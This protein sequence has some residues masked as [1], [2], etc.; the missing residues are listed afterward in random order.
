MNARRSTAIALVVQ[1]VMAS[2]CVVDALVTDSWAWF[3]W[4]C[5]AICAGFG[6][7]TLRQ[8]RSLR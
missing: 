2:V 1:I 7:I 5:A 3:S 6:V 4:L 8:Y